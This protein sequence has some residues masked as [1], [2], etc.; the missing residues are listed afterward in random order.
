MNKEGGLHNL[1]RAFSTICTATSES[2]QRAAPQ[3]FFMLCYGMLLG[4]G[5]TCLF[6]DRFLSEDRICWSVLCFA[7]AGCSWHMIHLFPSEKSS[8]FIVMCENV[9]FWN[10]FIDLWALNN[11]KKMVS[12]KA[13]L[14]L[15]YY[16]N[17]LNLVIGMNGLL[18]YSCCLELTVPK[19]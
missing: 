4:E 6:T 9:K 19:M 12:W 5:K 13:L 2:H 7:S 17:A 1:S 16:S 15:T 3:I 8:E 14:Y 18:Y 11:W 10:V